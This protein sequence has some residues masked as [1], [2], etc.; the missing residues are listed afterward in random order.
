MKKQLL[1]WAWY[2][3]Q[4][5]AEEFEP[6]KTERIAWRERIVQLKQNLKEIE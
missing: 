2:F 5:L 3:P 1:T 4:M 6:I